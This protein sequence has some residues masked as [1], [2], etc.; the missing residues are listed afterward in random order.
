MR[1]SARS[2]TQSMIPVRTV[3]NL[4]LHGHVAI[5]IISAE[6]AEVSRVSGILRRLIQTELFEKWNCPDDR[7][8]PWDVSEIEALSP[9]SQGVVRESPIF[10]WQRMEQRKRV[11]L[12][13]ANWI[14][15]GWVAPL[16]P[17]TIL[18]HRR[19]GCTLSCGAVTGREKEKVRHLS[20]DNLNCLHTK[21][22]DGKVSKRLTFVKQLYK[23]NTQRCSRWCRDVSINRDRWA[24]L[25]NKRD[26]GFPIP[27]S[28]ESV[29]LTYSKI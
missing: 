14:S 17:P 7:V 3:P 6:W 16:T 28:S 4:R 21:T 5:S 19:F 15:F 25:W 18:G 11:A 2:E 29:C 9:H 1:E 26:F 20:E 13:R 12:T 27:S 23:P 10:G 24:K 22:D 8:P